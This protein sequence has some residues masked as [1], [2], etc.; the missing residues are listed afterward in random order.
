MVARIRSLNTLP[1]S[2]AKPLAIILAVALVVQVV[3]FVRIQ[4][5][6]PSYGLTSE[7]YYSPPQRSTSCTTGPLEQG[8]IPT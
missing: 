7:H 3:Y 1:K 6:Y 4:A 8:S 2:E 5:E